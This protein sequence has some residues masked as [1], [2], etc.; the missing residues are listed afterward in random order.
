[1]SEVGPPPIIVEVSEPGAS[2]G[3]LRFAVD[4]ALRQRCELTIVHALSDSLT[5][6]LSKMQVDFSGRNDN[7]THDLDRFSAAE[8]HRLVTALARRAR[9]MSHG[10]VRDATDVPTGRQLHPIVKAAENARLVVLQHRDLPMV[11]R[12]FSHSASAGVTARAHC[13][14]VTVPH[15]WQPNLHHNRITVGI[16]DIESSADVLRIAFG[17]AWRREATL[18][19]AHDCNFISTEGLVVLPSNRSERALATLLLPWQ[20]QFPTVKVVQTLAQRGTIESLLEYS[21][22]SDLLILGRLRVRLSLPLPLG[23]VARAIVNEA[24]CPVEIVPHFVGFGA[25]R[26]RVPKTQRGLTSRPNGRFQRVLP[27]VRV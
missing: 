19:V 8:A 17:T 3:A 15:D 22:E 27:G 18:Y 1:M 20:R 7:S 4:E 24:K 5:A 16:A 9:A 10:Y 13:P 25:K 21:Q 6:P 14:V 12:V 26:I 11:E 23:S 2:E